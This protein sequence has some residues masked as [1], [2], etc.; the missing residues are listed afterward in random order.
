MP[1]LSLVLGFISYDFSNGPQPAG[2]NSGVGYATAR[3]I[4]SSSPK[5]HVII[6]ARSLS[7]AE[8]AIE[9]LHSTSKVQGTL[10][11][12]ELDVTSEPSIHA[13]VQ[14]VSMDFNGRLDILI[15]NAGIFSKATDLKTRFLDM[16]ATNVVGVALMTDAFAPLLLKS[17]RPY[18]INVSSALGS[19]GKASNPSD[20]TYAVYM[21]AYRA[22]KAALNMLTVEQGKELG[23]KG[24][25]VFAV[26]PGLVRS[27][28]R[29]TKEEERS[30]GGRAV[31]PQVS[32]EL[33]LGVLEGERDG[34]CWE[35]CV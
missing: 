19:L 20:P 5:Y 8:S 24:V 14:K 34:G 32:G 23:K 31:D 6:A 3:V 22:S 4:A 18:L 2:A 30:A 17:S 29:G 35:D 25:N 12:L 13:A 9:S 16:Y 15:N 28:L 7:K 11:P 1:F 10:S 33:I 27:N 26:C 21:T